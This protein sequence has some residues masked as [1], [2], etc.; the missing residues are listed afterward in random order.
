MAAASSASI[1][2]AS[3]S[4]GA[5]SRRVPASTPLVRLWAPKICSGTQKRTPAL[6]AKPR[7]EAEKSEARPAASPQKNEAAR[8]KG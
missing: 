8:W 1:D 5:G 3:E 6:V 7:S 2:Q 4:G